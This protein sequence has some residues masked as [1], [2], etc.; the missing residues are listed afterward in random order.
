[1][2]LGWINCQFYFKTEVHLGIF[3]RKLFKFGAYPN[4]LDHL[5]CSHAALTVFY[6]KFFISGSKFLSPS[7]NAV[8][9]TC[10]CAISLDHLKFR[11]LMFSSYSQNQDEFTASFISRRKF[12]DLFFEEAVQ[13]LSLCE[14][15]WSFGLQSSSIL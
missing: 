8:R 14:F 3:L 4:S 7:T 10:H 5:D 9:V 11:L 15:S 6:N 1:M 13:I 2:K 12:I